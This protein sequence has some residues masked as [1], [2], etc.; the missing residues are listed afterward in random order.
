MAE[1]KSGGSKPSENICIIT[2][3]DSKGAEYEV[4]DIFNMDAG[5]HLGLQK[6]PKFELGTSI[7]LRY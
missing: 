3:N 1:M 2:L 7:L 5:G 6:I 4:F